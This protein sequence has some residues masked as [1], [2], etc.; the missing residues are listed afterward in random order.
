MWLCC[1]LEKY[2]QGTHAWEPD[3]RKEG[4]EIGYGWLGVLNYVSA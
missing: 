2:K 1:V 4:T 3:V